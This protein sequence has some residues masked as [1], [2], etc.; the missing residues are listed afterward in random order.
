MTRSGPSTIATI[1]FALLAATAT[2]GDWSQFRGPGGLGIS[3]EKNVPIEWSATKNVVWRTPLPGPGTSSPVVAGD[4]V[5]V[6][7]YS[8]YALNSKKPGEMADLKRH[9]VCADRTT[10][11]IRWTQTC[12]PILPEHKYVGEGTYHGYSSSTPIIEGDRLYVFFG[13]SGVFCFDLDGKKVWHA[14]VGKN[15][16]G[17]GS[18]TSP[19]L[20]KNLL[21][22]NASVESGSLIALDKATGTEVWKTPGINSAWNTP[23]LTK[24][25]ERT[26]LI[27][28]VQDRLM[29]FDP[30]T[31]KEFWRAE[32]VH[33][34]VCTS[35][36]AHDG[37]IY[38]IG[39]GH[40]SLA[41]KAGGK[42]DVAATHGLWR[43]KKGSN[44]SSPIHH[45]G[46]IYWA[47]DNGGLVH[48]QD[49]ATGKFRYSERLSPAAG[50]IYA[51]PLLIDG[52]I[53]FVSQKTGTYVVAAQP[54]FAQL[55]HNGF[56]DDGSRTNASPA[57]AN[58]QLFMR[59]DRFLY[60]VGTK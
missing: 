29:S 36:I 58:G 17:W 52:K 21:I 34:Y 18:G 13:K 59:S 7:C 37:I 2:A 5:Y 45:E 32:G 6:T 22:V 33:R 14:L 23:L 55:A 9:L 57:V 12:D 3:A 42:G 11:T 50:L 40:T 48:C 49:A 30:D 43:E 19:I 16:N 26:E 24:T 60:C 44:V 8:G 15:T 41:V 10:G 51:S 46:H 35:P 20:H 1:L 56:A 25:A 27:V 31:G 54:K 38:A 28:S 4:R 53:Y 47:S 39:G